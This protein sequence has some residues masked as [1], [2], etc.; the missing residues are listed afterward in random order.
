MIDIQ[1]AVRQ[2]EYSDDLGDSVDPKIG[3]NFR[4]LDWMTVRGS[5]ATSFRA[6]SLR[7]VVG[8]D[9]S[10][11]VTEV[12]DPIDPIE[13]NTGTGTFR[14]ILLSKNTELLPEEST[15]WNVGV[16]FLP[17]L[18]WGDDTHDF[19]I[20]VDYFLFEFENRIQ[21]KPASLV[22]QEDP[23]GPNVQRDPI[24]FIPGPLLVNDPTGNCGAG[25]VGN[26]LIVNQSF[27][28]SGGTDISGVDVSARYSFDAWGRSDHVEERDLLHAGLRNRG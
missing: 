17:E 19:Q 23:C 11:F 21:V 13:F 5:Y 24:N 28:N 9:R 3:I 6:P 7:Q 1:L 16:S 22:V 14:T 2:E 10:A 26:V 4:P 8:N 12:Q 18:P 25:P 15:N 20:D 27:L